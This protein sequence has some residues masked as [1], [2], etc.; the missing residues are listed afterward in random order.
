MQNGKKRSIII[1]YM[2]SFSASMYVVIGL[3][4]KITFLGVWGKK[5]L[6]FGLIEDCEVF[7]HTYRERE[8]ERENYEIFSL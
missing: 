8:R 6:I 3:S 7:L 5:I 2:T 1:K 4:L